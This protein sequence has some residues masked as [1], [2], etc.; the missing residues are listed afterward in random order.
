[1]HRQLPFTTTSGNNRDT[2]LT[3]SHKY[4]E[5]LNLCTSMLMMNTITINMNKT[6]TNNWTE[7]TNVKNNLTN[8]SIISKFNQLSITQSH[9]FPTTEFQSHESKYQVS[10]PSLLFDFTS[11]LGKTE[12]S[13]HR[14]PSW[15]NFLI[16]IYTLFTICGATFNLILIFALLK[17]RK[18]TLSH[19]ITNLFVLCLAVSDIFLCSVSMPIQLY[20]E[21]TEHHKPSTDLCRVLFSSFGL[22]MYISC[23]TILLIAFDRY[24][25]IVYPLKT[26]LTPKAAFGLIITVILFSALNSIPVALQVNSEGLN[27]YHYC[28]ESWPSPQLRFAYS[29]S[30]FAILVLLPLSAS[31][32]FYLA[33]Y[34]RLKQRPCQLNV[35]KEAEKRK[36]RTT[37]LLVITVVCFAICWT[38][39][40]LYSLLLEVQALLNVDNDLSSTSAYDLTK[41][42]HLFNLSQYINDKDDETWKFSIGLKTCEEFLWH[43]M[44]QSS[45]L[46]L[47]PKM[48]ENFTMDPSVDLLKP[49]M[50]LIPG[51][52]LKIIDLLLKLFAMSSA[53]VNPLLYGWLNEPIRVIMRR[54]YSR[55]EGC[56]QCLRISQRDTK[57]KNRISKQNLTNKSWYDKRK[58]SSNF[59]RIPHLVK[60]N[61]DYDTRPKLIIDKPTA[62]KQMNDIRSVSYTEGDVDINRDLLNQIENKGALD[63]GILINIDNNN[64]DLNSNENSF[65]LLLQTKDLN[66]LENQ[67]TNH[68]EMTGIK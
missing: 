20:Y 8:S 48:N 3:M 6:F 30:I 9:N 19:N 5:L 46:V 50:N 66:L 31:G 17:F 40:C 62:S 52:H 15:R 23:L 61:S 49:K 12:H 58:S 39:W 14:I 67:T 11:D 1:M 36:K 34:R 21:M 13:S 27:D 56:F 43:A 25:L 33:I 35:S 7:E 38:P 59:L 28:V 44:N 18:Q 68:Y 24:R 42:S 54:Q 16:C 64:N 57:N 55:F 53:C 60:S 22:P 45:L 26:Q 10:S 65:D 32:G 41:F 29:V 47:L 37:S 63:I 4:T 51:K 2:L